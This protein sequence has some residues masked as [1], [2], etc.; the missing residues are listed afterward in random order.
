M[1]KL[2]PPRETGDPNSSSNKVGVFLDKLYKNQKQFSNILTVNR[3]IFK[4]KNLLYENPFSRY[5][6]I[7]DYDLTMISYYENESYYLPHR[8]CYTI[9][10]VT[11]FWKKPKIFSGGELFFYNYNYCPKM[12]HNTMIL[13]PSYEDH[14]VSEIFMENNDGINGRYTIN[15]FYG[16]IEG[17]YDGE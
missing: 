8:D 12:D 2:L 16:I 4:I 13:F 14:G 17:L 1:G 5:L 3:K 7:T 10:S 6:D 15:Q 11:T 9:S